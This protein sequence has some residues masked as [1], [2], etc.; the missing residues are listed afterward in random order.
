MHIITL[1]L[2][3]LKSP[4]LDCQIDISKTPNKHPKKH[5]ADLNDFDNKSTYFM[6]ESQY[7]L[8]LDSLQQSPL[9]Y[10]ALEK[11]LKN[12]IQ[13]C[14]VQ[15]DIKTSSL[16]LAPTNQYL[17]FSDTINDYETDTMTWLSI[18]IDI[19]HF[20]IIN[21]RIDASL[22][23]LY[24]INS[25]LKT[26][27]K[28]DNSK[29]QDPIFFDIELS[30]R[31][32]VALHGELI[33]KCYKSA[34][35]FDNKANPLPIEFYQK[36]ND[37][38]TTPHQKA[39]Y[40][41]ADNNLFL[42]FE[43]NRASPKK[44][45]LKNR[46]LVAHHDM[47]EAISPQKVNSL[48][49]QSSIDILALC[50]QCLMWDNQQIILCL[51][52]FLEKTAV[53]LSEVERQS[54]FNDFPYPPANPQN[55]PL[56][57]LINKIELELIKINTLQQSTN[58]QFDAFN[59]TTCFPDISDEVLKTHFQNAYNHFAQHNVNYSF[60]L[61]GVQ[62]LIPAAGRNK[63]LKDYAKILK[64]DQ[65]GYMR[66]R[67]SNYLLQNTDL[68]A[69]KKSKE[70]LTDALNHKKTALQNTLSRIEEQEK[71]HA[72]YQQCLKILDFN[73]QLAQRNIDEAIDEINRL[74][75]ALDNE[76]I[77]TDELCK[78][79]VKHLEKHQKNYALT[80]KL[81]II[82]DVDL[83]AN[84]QKIFRH[85]EDFVDYIVNDFNQ[86]SPL[87]LTFIQKFPEFFI[88]TAKPDATNTSSFFEINT[89]TFDQLINADYEKTC[90]IV[91][92]C[93]LLMHEFEVLRN[94]LHVPAEDSADIIE[95]LSAALIHFYATRLDF[96]LACSQAH[97]LLSSDDVNYQKNYLHNIEIGLKNRLAF[98]KAYADFVNTDKIINESD[99]DSFCHNEFFLQ[100]RQFYM[101]LPMLLS[102]LK[103]FNQPQ[104][105]T[106]YVASSSCP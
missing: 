16:G 64:N 50:N 18:V 70:N 101:P 11:I 75:G 57:E 77:R 47:P 1:N 8:I 24:P 63:R 84:C 65:V 104:A 45:L 80:K 34:F 28:I 25:A 23:T 61:A 58:A 56:N 100:G 17:R 102:Q 37:S 86:K 90:E 62:F 68:E 87:I 49:K 83:R 12:V 67:L 5:L 99:I 38:N 6:D 81:D 21:E 85:L 82:F 66:S 3:G 53:T 71:S 4:L 36:V 76:Q 19:T 22:Q 33:T 93:K 59:A 69:I 41:G 44:S 39:F 40:L 43:T 55:H 98:E 26:T 29:A 60:T 88:Q 103:Q 89:E 105:V 13:D 72:D 54:L 94:N 96:P 48:Q 30:H 78:A 31:N 91:A 2:E 73:K 92:I 32:A 97:S 10:Q 74:F 106:M 27:E 46:A 95:E 7:Q 79:L 52:N 35:A 15:F 42:H 9:L 20:N 51:Q 14:R